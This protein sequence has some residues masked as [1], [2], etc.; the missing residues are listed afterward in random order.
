VVH[1]NTEKSIIPSELFLSVTCAE[2]IPEAVDG[3]REL[4]LNPD[5]QA[6]AREW[7]LK[8]HS[9]AKVLDEIYGA[10]WDG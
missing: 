9:A 6:A 4:A 3:S 7:V 2:E 1:T 10:L 8:E 5:R